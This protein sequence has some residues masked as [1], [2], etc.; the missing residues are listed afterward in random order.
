MRLRS[1]PDAQWEIRQYSNA[2]YQIFSE[3]MPWTAQA[4]D[5]FILGLDKK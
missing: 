5:K 2:L 3:F 1:A 4:F